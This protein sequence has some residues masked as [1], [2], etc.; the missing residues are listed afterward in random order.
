MT[1]ASLYEPASAFV[2]TSASSSCGDAGAN[3]S[4]YSKGSQRESI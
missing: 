1:T 4:R 2:D 3:P